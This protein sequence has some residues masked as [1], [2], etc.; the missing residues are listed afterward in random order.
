MEA[1]KLPK[2]RMCVQFLTLIHVHL[3]YERLQKP[4]FPILFRNS[5]S[6]QRKDYLVIEPKEINEDLEMKNLPTA[7]TLAGF[8]NHTFLLSSIAGS[9]SH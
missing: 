6:A 5:P 1:E 4:V 9:L 3:M 2:N 7:D 8:F